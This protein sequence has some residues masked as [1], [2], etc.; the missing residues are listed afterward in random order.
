MP[1]CKLLP[2]MIAATCMACYGRPGCSPGVTKK[3][4][5]DEVAV[6]VV[7]VV[8]VVVVAARPVIARERD[9]WA[10]VVAGPVEPVVVVMVMVIV[11]H[12]H[13]VRARAGRRN[14]V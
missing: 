10:I 14:G 11:L 3:P 4:S 5:A 6:V 8:M 1:P 12:L 9:D 13:D 7:V 2:A